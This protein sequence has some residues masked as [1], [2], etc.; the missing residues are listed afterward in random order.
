MNVFRYIDRQDEA[1][2]TPEELM[3]LAFGILSMSDI[4]KQEREAVE[5]LKEDLEEHAEVSTAVSPLIGR[6]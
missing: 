1:T 3:E 4:L 6:T 5:E 2:I